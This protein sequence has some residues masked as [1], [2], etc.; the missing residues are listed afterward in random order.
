MHATIIL[1]WRGLFDKIL[2]M[3]NL[4]RERQ[5]AG[6]AF[7]LVCVKIPLWN[8]ACYDISD[9]TVKH[10]LRLNEFLN[11]FISRQFSLFTVLIIGSKV[12]MKSLWVSYAHDYE[13]FIIWSLSSAVCNQT[14]NCEKELIQSALI[15]YFL[16]LCVVYICKKY[17]RP[18]YY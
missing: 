9:S 18:K 14:S 11:E 2:T 6:S 13:Q 12:K 8:G 10:C 17:S 4:P 15:A 3:I 1:L 7:N 5:L 16:T